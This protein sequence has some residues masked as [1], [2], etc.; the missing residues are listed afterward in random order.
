[1]PSMRAAGSGHV[2]SV[3]SV[4]GVVGQPFNDAYCAA[5]FATEGMMESFAP[6][7]AKFGVAVTV[8]EPGPVASEFVDNVRDELGEMLEDTDDPYHEMFSAYV[9]RATETFSN[10]QAAAEVGSVIAGVVDAEA[11]AFRVQTSPG[12]TAFAGMKL[13]DVDGSTVQV[14]T[15]SW[16]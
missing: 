10:A 7:A 9:S 15:R 8:V 2:I 16:V 6:V 1:M 3:T 12:S 4:G 14:A 11:P 13:S 5:K